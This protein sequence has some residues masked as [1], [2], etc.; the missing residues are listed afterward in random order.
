MGSTANIWFAVISAVA[1]LLSAVI[2]SWFN[3]LNNRDQMTHAENMAAAQRQHAE[4]MATFEKRLEA[5]QEVYAWSH[6][7]F[8][9]IVIPMNPEIESDKDKINQALLQFLNDI[10]AKRRLYLSGSVVE[11][12]MLTA[13]AIIDFRNEKIVQEDAEKQLRKL[14]TEILKAMDLPL[15]QQEG[16]LNDVQSQLPPSA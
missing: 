1:I 8:A 6:D 9:N 13:R 15:A 5:H 14:G 2:A 7:M 10:L 4:R 11:E 12:I 16:I 3:R